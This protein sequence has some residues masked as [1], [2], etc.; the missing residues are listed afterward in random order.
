MIRSAR[1]EC[2]KNAAGL[3]K[4]EEKAV[5][6]VFDGLII[7][8]IAMAYAGVS[9]PASGAEHYISHIIDMRGLQFGTKIELHGIQCAIAT[10]VV[11]K[12]YDKLK[13]V[14]INE[15]KAEK[16]TRAFDKRAW[17][18]NLRAFLGG[19]AEPM[20]K[21]EEKE[22]KYDFD[23]AAARRK[24]IVRKWEDLKRI[25]GEE[26][27]SA[28]KFT[29]IL[30]AAGIPDTFEKAGINIDIKKAFAATKDIRDKY[31]L[32]SL[33]WDIGLLGEFCGSL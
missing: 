8:G 17:E 16:E 1:E 25:M 12:L 14:T 19:A 20:I 26:L 11:A 5:K 28:Q 30:A 4:R 23:K 29:E 18:E 15:E 32:S 13:S 10:L 3:I 22:R 27:P 7:G 6:A 9:R 31:V 21:L 33:L 2:V 24:V